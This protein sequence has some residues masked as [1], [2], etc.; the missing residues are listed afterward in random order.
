MH[1]VD[2]FDGFYGDR[3]LYSIYQPSWCQNNDGMMMYAFGFGAINAISQAGAKYSRLDRLLFETMRSD[4]ENVDTR[5]KGS[6]VLYNLIE[7]IKNLLL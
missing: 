2:W 4:T 7:C 1:H 6:L 3:T 5:G